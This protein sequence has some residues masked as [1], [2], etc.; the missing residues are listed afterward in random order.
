[1]AQGLIVIASDPLWVFGEEEEMDYILNSPFIFIFPLFIGIL[2]KNQKKNMIWLLISTFML[3]ITTL[4]WRDINPPYYWH[5][6]L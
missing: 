4:I 3:G 1:M 5:D 6:I 2:F